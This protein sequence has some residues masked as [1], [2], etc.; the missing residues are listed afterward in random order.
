MSGHF[1]HFPW[2]SMT[3][4]DPKAPLERGTSV[5]EAEDAGWVS[6]PGRVE[7]RDPASKVP[8]DV[9][10]VV[11]PVDRHGGGVSRTHRPQGLAYRPPHL[12]HL[13]YGGGT[14]PPGRFAEPIHNVNFVYCCFYSL[15][16]DS[17]VF[18]SFFTARAFNQCYNCFLCSNPYI[19]LKCLLII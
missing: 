8:P 5:G 7:S 11:V 14:F 1:C 18:V 3:F 13:T 16:S 15:D 10:D 2:L 4:Q 9:M 19:I 6:V 17:H 12:R